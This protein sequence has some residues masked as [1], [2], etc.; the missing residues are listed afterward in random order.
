M[1]HILAGQQ[2]VTQAEIKETLLRNEKQAMLI[3]T[4]Q[5]AEVGIKECINLKLK[6][7]EDFI[8]TER[9]KLGDIPLSGREKRR[10]RRKQQRKRKY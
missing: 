6:E 8:I 1:K 10:E 7:V 4:E 3:D 2:A 5:K 9:E